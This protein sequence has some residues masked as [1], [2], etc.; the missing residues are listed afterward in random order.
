MKTMTV[1]QT[2]D[3]LLTVCDAIIENKPLLTEVDSKIGDGDHGIGMAGGME[4]AKAAL[5]EKRPFADINT[6]FKTMG[7]AM[8][9]SMGGASGVI[10]GSMFLGGIKGADTISELTPEAL[11]HMMRKAVEAIKERGKAKVGDKTMVDAF[12]PAV[13]AME[14]ADKE[15]ITELLKKAKDAAYQGVENTKGYIARFG[16]AKSLME[17][18]VGF[19]DAGATSVAI[20]FESMYEFAKDGI[21]S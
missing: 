8:L 16:R 3:M 20:I 4:K 12:E 7:M 17:R 5:T 9:N 21:T 13:E 15:D 11:A 10:F 19:Q 14:A 6:V 18:A 1:E 2:T